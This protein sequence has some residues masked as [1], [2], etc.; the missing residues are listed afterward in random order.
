MKINKIESCNFKAYDN[1]ERKRVLPISIQEKTKKL[2]YE[3]NHQ[4]TFSL[5]AD[6]TETLSNVLSSL[7]ITDK[8]RF[9]DNRFYIM[10]LEE[11]QKHYCDC[12]L[13]IG[14]TLL[15]INSSTGEIVSYKKGFFKTWK[16]ILSE[17]ENLMKIFLQNIN[18]PEVVKKD[19]I[20]ILNY[21]KKGQLLAIKKLYK[22]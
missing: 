20:P 8:Y 7:N 3:M 16:S 6:K 22:L 12:T 19:F 17:A 1:Y 2:L 18:N 5:N 10:P 21:T 15:N 13:Q 9:V 14:K 4:T 11:P